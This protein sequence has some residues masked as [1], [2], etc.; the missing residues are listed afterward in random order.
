MGSNSIE[1]A[2]TKNGIGV[3]YYMKEEYAEAL[4][5]YSKCLEIQTKVLGSDSIQ[6]ATTLKNIGLVYSKR[7][8]FEKA[9]EQLNKCLEI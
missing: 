8:E 9:F 2:N 7:G 5:Q 1:I 6:V 3:A 4:E